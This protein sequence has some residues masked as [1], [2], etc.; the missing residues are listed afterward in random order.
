ML[1]T[2]TPSL[3][4]CLMKCTRYRKQ[5]KGEVKFSYELDDTVVVVEVDVQLA[6]LAA[7]G[8]FDPCKRDDFLFVVFLI[9][10]AP[11]L[12]KSIFSRMNYV[13]VFNFFNK[14]SPTER[15]K[16]GLSLSLLINSMNS[17]ELSNTVGLI[18]DIRTHGFDE[19]IVFVAKK[20]NDGRAPNSVNN[21]NPWLWILDVATNSFWSAPYGKQ[22]LQL[23]EMLNY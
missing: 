10:R 14:V 7:D 8:S 3:T 1:R 21:S 12:R 4:D 9:R 19:W 18:C 23:V 2:K 11:A 6:L 16:I 15:A 5:K 20:M 17:I 13:E 22:E